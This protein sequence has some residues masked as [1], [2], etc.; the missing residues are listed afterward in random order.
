MALA[1]GRAGAVATDEELDNHDPLLWMQEYAFATRHTELVDVFFQK[2]APHRDGSQVDEDSVLV[3]RTNFY[4]FWKGTLEATTFD[5]Y[6]NQVQELMSGNLPLDSCPSLFDLKYLDTLIRCQALATLLRDE[7]VSATFYLQQLDALFPAGAVVDSLPMMAQQMVKLVRD[8]F[9]ELTVGLPKSAKAA[10]KALYE[11]GKAIC[12]RRSPEW[13]ADRFKAAL[14]QVETSCLGKPFL[15]QLAINIMDKRDPLDGIRDP[16]SVNFGQ[17]SG[18]RNN[19]E[20]A[21]SSSS[22]ATGSSSQALEPVVVNSAA[23]NA[24]EV[25]EESTTYGSSKRVSLAALERAAGDEW[26]AIV[27]RTHPDVRKFL[28][29]QRIAAEA[30]SNSS[31]QS[32]SPA[33]QC[34]ES[35]ENFAGGDEEPDADGATDVEEEEEAVAAA[36]TQQ[37]SGAASS[38]AATVRA[39]LRS[40]RQAVDKVCFF[41]QHFLML[42]E[43]SGT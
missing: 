42:A 37:D 34:T 14:Q 41:I 43:V 27:Q 10:G 36:A 33:E 30:G 12:A 22:N 6:I 31:A 16:L 21:A 26:G 9:F 40:A 38:S 2:L 13:F 5:D 17:S 35:A 11:R 24:A 8:E 20:A 3:A 32:V 7:N 15:R 19:G 28:D 18:S 39:E 29:S 1:S 23:N 25:V 4:L